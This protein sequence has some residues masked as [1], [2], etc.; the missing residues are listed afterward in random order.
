MGVYLL[1]AVPASF[2]LYLST[3]IFVSICISFNLIL[4]EQLMTL[5]V[6]FKQAVFSSLRFLYS[7]PCEISAVSFTQLSRD[8]VSFLLPSFKFVSGFSLFSFDFL[9]DFE[10]L[11]PGDILFIFLGSCLLCSSN[12][13]FW[14]LSISGFKIIRNPCS[15]FL[16]PSPCRK[17]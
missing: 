5:I 2:H 17:T 8:D 16:V 15:N 13:F 6:I 3:S 1:E 9:S 7:M 10:F 14:V 11:L 12:Q 4:Y